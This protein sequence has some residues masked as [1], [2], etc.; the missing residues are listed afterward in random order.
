MIECVLV[1][2]VELEVMMACNQGAHDTRVD[3]GERAVDNT[4]MLNAYRRLEGESV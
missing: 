3:Y 1:A 4:R 2:S